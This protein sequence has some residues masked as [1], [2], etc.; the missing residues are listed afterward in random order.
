[1]GFCVFNQI[2]TAVRH[3]QAAHGLQRIAVID[4]DVHHGNGTQDIFY[5]DPDV[6]VS[7]GTDART[8]K[9][10]SKRIPLQ[11]PRVDPI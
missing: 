5:D 9:L 2:S 6:L 1:M 7:G 11:T 4:F 10:P 8:C 3:A